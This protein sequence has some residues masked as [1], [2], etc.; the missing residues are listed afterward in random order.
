VHAVYQRHMEKC[1]I[2]DDDD[3][4]IF[5]GQFQG[6]RTTTTSKR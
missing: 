2:P 5:C 3:D 6:H 4:I 1:K